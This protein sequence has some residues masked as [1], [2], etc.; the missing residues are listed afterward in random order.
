MSRIDDLARRSALRSRR[1]GAVNGLALA[2]ASP[3]SRRRAFRLAAVAAGTSVFGLRTESAQ[4]CASCPQMFDPPNWTQFCG[5]A[6]GV[7]CKF[8]CCPPEQECCT[9]EGGVKCCKTDEGYECG[10]V[11]NDIPTCRCKTPCYADCCRPGEECVITDPED[12]QGFCD[13]G[14]DPG[15]TRC[16]WS[17]YVCCPHDYPCCGEGCCDPIFTCCSGQGS[18]ERRNDT[19]CG[20]GYVCDTS[21]AFPECQCLGPLKCGDRCCPLGQVCASSRYPAVCRG[22]QWDDLED[23]LDS[24]GQTLSNAGAA[25]GGSASAS[26]KLPARLSA[27]SGT[28]DALV[29]IGAVANLGA[30]AYDRLRSGRPDSAYRRSVRALKPRLAPLAPGPG[31]D[32]SAAHALHRLLSAEARAWALVN[33]ATLAQ[34]RSL[35]AIRARDL[36]AARSQARAYGRFAGQAAKALRRVPALRAAALAALQAGGT[37]EVTV[38]DAQ[39]RAFQDSVRKGGLPAE[40]KARLTQ[41]GLRR[42]DQRRV[43]KVVLA[44]RPRGGPVLIAPLADASRLAATTRLAKLFKR[45]AARS[46]RQPLVRSTTR[47]GTVSG[48]RPHTSQASRRRPR[49]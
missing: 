13:P 27:A 39:F 48:A 28:T 23:L 3:I 6:V 30:L 9:A 43:A 41:L 35:G 16:A 1:V 33:A 31:L 2:L 40:M 18:G 42:A 21:S 37:P 15:R 47:P 36:V 25:I 38:T 26:R 46:R 10:P 17:P 14:C 29:A 4:A 7:G 32:A 49:G 22:P 11:V 20:P 5:Y 19:C 8:V 44:T 24:L 12:G 34:G 45:T